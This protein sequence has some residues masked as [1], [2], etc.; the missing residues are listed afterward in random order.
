MTPDTPSRPP[1]THKSTSRSQ[2]GGQPRSRT[3]PAW[4]AWPSTPSAGRAVRDCLLSASAGPGPRMVARLC[5]HPP[6]PPHG[7]PPRSRSDRCRPPPRRA[8]DHP[9]VRKMP[10]R[11]TAALARLPRSPDHPGPAPPFNDRS[12]I[13]VSARSRKHKSD[14]QKHIRAAPFWVPPR[15]THTCEREAPGFF[16]VAR[17]TDRCTGQNTFRTDPHSEVVG[18]RPA[19]ACARS[20]RAGRE[21]CAQGMPGVAPHDAS[22]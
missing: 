15:G 2:S 11:W 5:P 4:M 8:L 13:W 1:P 20:G 12:G 7:P 17:C 21:P 10:A 9:I 18:S 16:L 22:A 19:T 14:G 6:M 3:L